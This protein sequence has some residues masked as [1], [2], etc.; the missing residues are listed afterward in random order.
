[1]NK[2]TYTLFSPE[3][4]IYY[5]E[6]KG[7]NGNIVKAVVFSEYEENIF[8]MALLDY[9]F[10]TEEFS[11]MSSSNNGDMTKVLATVAVIVDAF[12]QNNP[13]YTVY[14]EGNTKAKNKLYNRIIKNN[15]D[16]LVENYEI[17][18]R[19]EDKQDIYFKE[20]QYDGFYIYKK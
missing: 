12:L 6:S 3:N 20:N 15:Y 9:D 18:G 17:R 7:V 13:S 1:M 2:D 5:F 10:Q 4:N 8:N 19:I 14:F 11:D 16:F